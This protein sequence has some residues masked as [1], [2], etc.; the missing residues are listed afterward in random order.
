M[1][2]LLNK[3]GSVLFL[4]VVV[5]SILI[6]AASATFYVVNNQSSSVTVRYSSEQS[7]QT[8]VS[9]SDMV[10]QY[11]DDF[12]NKLN[13]KQIDGKNYEDNL[14]VKMTKLNDNESFVTDDIDLS[15]YNLG[16]KVNVEITKISTVKD[17]TA[18]T[19]THNF[20]IV[21]KAEVNGEVSTVTQIKAITTTSKINSA[22]PF[23]K[24][25]TSTGQSGNGLDVYIN[26]A[27][28][29]GQLYFENEYSSCTGHVNTSIYCS[30]TFADNGII[31]SKLDAGEK[32]EMVVA[33]DLYLTVSTNSGT[34]TNLSE[35]F[36]GGNMKINKAMHVEKFYVM[37]DL[38][39][40]SNTDYASDFIVHGDCYIGSTVNEMKKSRFFVNGDLYFDNDGLLYDH[41]PEGFYVKGKI[42]R[43]KSDGSG[44]EEIDVSTLPSSSQALLKDYESNYKA[45][46]SRD[47]K[48][49]DGTEFKINTWDDVED[50]IAKKASQQ[51]YTTWDAED[52]FD[53]TLFKD[54]VPNEVTPGQIDPTT[55]ALEEIVTITQ[56]CILHPSINWS[57]NYNKHYIVIDTDTNGGDVYIK[58]VPNSG[59]TFSFVEYS[60][61]P[62]D[63]SGVNVLVRGKYSVVFI[64]PD[65][66]E[67]K[68]IPFSYVGHEDLAMEMAGVT[69]FDDLLK[70]E[71]TVS[72]Y[73]NMD[74]HLAN[75]DKLTNNIMDTD[76]DL[77][78]ITGASGKLHNNIFLAT[79]ST[80]KT[81]D[82]GNTGTFCGYVYAPRCTLKCDNQFN[83]ISFIGGMVV[84]NYSYKNYRAYLYFLN[85][86]DY[87]NTFSPEPPEDIVANLM[88]NSGAKTP[89]GDEG[90]ITILD[91]VKSLGYK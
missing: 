31:Y 35:V 32:R 20:S 34:T 83:Q 7:Y 64:L 10:S 11:I 86:Y 67:Y 82:F 3:K 21:S 13:K 81:L 43:K 29:F 60:G 84:S 1:K 33:E 58:L 62:W 88:K 79:K 4:V 52:Y 22:E 71:R 91:S 18:G 70:G 47:L 39:V 15:N 61:N 46:L 90:S 89:G 16:E 72:N 55:H 59:N 54:T 76:T 25:L 40:T 87:N 28:I 5:M 49:E 27:D 50:Y 9:V 44:Y 65:G 75:K 48:L 57:G 77:F 74:T 26:A 51:E 73:F 63:S 23:T 56:S 41:I 36:V 68:Q 8:A 30:K 66:T 24:F 80:G 78:K 53:N 14:L 12:G 19:T 2:K 17:E 38:Y 42:Y 37:N 6:I 85:P 45:A 69:S